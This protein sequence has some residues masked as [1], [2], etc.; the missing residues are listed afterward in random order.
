MNLIHFSTF[1]SSNRR[2]SGIEDEN[3][4]VSEYEDEDGTEVEENNF[5]NEENNN[6]SEY[7]TNK[8]PCNL[9]NDVLYDCYAV[10]NHSGTLSG[11]HY[12][13][14]C[15]HPFNQVI[16]NKNDNDSGKNYETE[17]ELDDESTWY[18]YNDRAVSRSNAENVIS[19]DA[20]LL[21]FE[22]V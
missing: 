22:K 19:G 12:T 18:L 8:S 20:Y 7:G 6:N 11:G 15:R 17:H 9:N 4:E 10:S 13:A 16:N 5:Q 1:S 21:F 3:D 14:Y 2:E